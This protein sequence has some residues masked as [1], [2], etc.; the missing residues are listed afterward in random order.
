MP[1]N[2]QPAGGGRITVKSVGHRP[3]P[4]FT[5]RVLDNTQHPAADGFTRIGPD[6]EMAEN[7]RLGIVDIDPV[8]QSDPHTVVPAYQ[9][10]ADTVARHPVAIL[11]CIVVLS[12]IEPV[13]TVEPVVGPEPDE[14]QRILHNAVNTIRR[15][16][17]LH[18]IPTR[19]NAVRGT[20]RHDR[21]R[22]EQ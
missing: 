20:G 10:P 9:Q 22:C 21:D 2:P 17:V 4:Q 15:K 12:E 6:V 11:A 16:S 8:V 13:E 7:A 5:V 14:A 19:Y 3:D 18:H 1:V